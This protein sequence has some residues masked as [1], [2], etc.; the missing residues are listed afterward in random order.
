MH[1]GWEELKI[2]TGEVVRFG[3]RC[4]DPQWHNLDRY[5]ESNFVD[6]NWRWEFRPVC[7]LLMRHLGNMPKG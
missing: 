1:Y 3:N 4:K 5:L 6:I 2:F 7:L